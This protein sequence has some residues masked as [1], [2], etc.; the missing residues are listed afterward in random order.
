MRRT[1]LWS[2]LTAITAVLLAAVLIASNVASAFSG[3]ISYFLGAETSKLVP[4]DGSENLDTMYYKTSFGDG[5]FTLENQRLLYAA[6][7]EQTANEM[8]EGAVLLM[9]NEV[10][11]APALPLTTETRVTLLGHSF[12]QPGWQ[13]ASAGTIIVED[14]YD[15]E[16]TGDNSWY[17]VVTIQEALE[18]EG[19]VYNPTVQ[20]A[21]K[22]SWKTTVEH[23]LNDNLQPDDVIRGTMSSRN[24]APYPS[25]AVRDGAATSKNSEHDKAYYEDLSGSWAND[26]NDVAIVMFTREGCEGTDL[27]M[28][29]MDDDGGKQGNISQL[30]LHKNERDL[31]EI[32]RRDFKK[33]IVLLNSPNQMEVHEIEPLC[34]AILFIGFPGHQGFT[35]VAEILRGTTNPSGHLVDTYAV[36]SL[37]APSTVN[38][39]TNS[40]RYGNVDEVAA[41]HTDQGMS[42]TDKEEYY[43]FQAEG[44]YIGYRYYET[45]YADSVMGTGNATD[46]V[47]A[48]SGADSWNYA[49]E[50]S[51]TFGHGLSYTTFEQKIDSFN[52]GEDEITMTVTVT[53]TGDAAGKS[54]VQAYAQTPYGAYEKERRIEKS[55][56][57]LAGFAKTQ[58]LAPGASEQV[59]ITIDKY[60]LA[61]YDY[62]DAKGYV[63]TPGKYHIAIG[64]D[65]HDAL[66]NILAAQGYTTA[67]G[68]TADGDASKTKNFNQANADTDKYKY[69]ENGVVVTNQFDDCDLN[70]WLEGAGTYLSRSDW[71][72][73]YP[74]APTIISLTTEMMDVLDGDFYETPENA[75]T[76]DEVA[77]RFGVDS[78][79]TIAS[80]RD[81][82]ISDRQTWEKFIY[83]IGIDELPTATQ[84]GF[85]C[86]AVGTLSPSFTVGDGCDSTMATL[87]FT[88]TVNGKEITVKSARYTSKS[89]LTGTFNSD[90][91]TMRGFLMGEDG[92]WG[93]CMENYNV[94][95]NLHRTPFGGRNPEY[96]T[97]CPTM[98]YLAAIP[99]VLA[100]EQTGSHSAP[101]HFTG[102]DQE[103][104]RR[105]HA[106]FFNEQAFR[107]GNLRA[108]EGAIRVAKSGGL[109]QSFERIGLKWATL[110]KPLNT[111]ILRNEW[112]WTGNIVTDAAGLRDVT[113]M[114][115]GYRAHS[116]EGFEAGSEQWC[117]DTSNDA[118]NGRAALAW[119]KD[120]NDG[121]I[122]ELMVDAAI[123]WEYAIAHSVVVNGMAPGDIAVSITPWW[124]TALTAVT[125]GLGVLTAASTVVLVISVVKRKED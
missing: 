81:I 20:N 42:W 91:Y 97:E 10:D 93:G 112:G 84:E 73:T 74:A 37:S 64:E 35:G 72:G 121:H 82:P 25:G 13:I 125:I 110:S 89:I 85:T 58:L 92:L 119:A 63:L 115:L 16:A 2:G 6:T 102:N 124:Q 39:G 47:G 87:P 34:D 55:A 52:V 15:Y 17:Q 33:V 57:Q 5:T 94:G 30:A 56:I 26:Y 66:N 69:G 54:V 23:A 60:L 7:M 107:E 61:S 104:A 118:G 49:D 59:T 95:A 22:S 14:A 12:V 83:Q 50:M 8:R 44:I 80:M 105:G 38:G 100:M 123:S 79:L 111:N 77:A 120:H 101:K 40:P 106:A 36:S 78:G 90:L 109:M 76:Y 1:K 28:S 3:E 62:V 65:C 117:L 53:N 67:N 48:I 11:G 113:T 75:P 27:N 24:G 46:K 32:A 4:V 41:F 71:A 108:F 88:E 116:L 18:K 43:S 96:M 68:M 45:R 29:D 114:G 19:F 21:L 98:A 31:L 70:Y 51:Y 99:E 122:V 9:N 103:F 86:P